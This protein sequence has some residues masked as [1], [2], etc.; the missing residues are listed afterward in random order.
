[1]TYDT[2]ILRALS[3]PSGPSPFISSFWPV[4]KL[5]KEKQHLTVDYHNLKVRELPIKVSLHYY[6]INDSL[7]SGK[8]FVVIDLANMLYPV[9]ISTDSQ[10]HIAFTFKG[11]KEVSSPTSLQRT[12]SALLLHTAFI[13]KI[14]SVFNFLGSVGTHCTSSSEK[15]F[16]PLFQDIQISTEKLTKGTAHWPTH[17]AKS[18]HLG[19]I[20]DN[21]LSS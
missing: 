3:A 20:P 13:G 1:M 16:G 17:S 18:H 7:Q 5:G 15:V 2:I 8:Y 10:K 11:T 12:S 4:L 21:Y 9:S 14:L 6:A 19:Y